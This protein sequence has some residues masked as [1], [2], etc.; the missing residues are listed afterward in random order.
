MASIGT[1]D[2]AHLIP[3]NL[4]PYTAIVILSLGVLIFNFLWNTINMYKP[5][6]GE[7]CTYLDYFK[8]GSTKTH[9]VGML[10]GLI[11]GLGTAFSIIASGA[12]RP[13]R[14]LMD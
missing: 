11:W 12:A 8:K 4:S 2:F 6:A 1:V 14:Y 7:K 13:L 10:G 5:I 9:L 3:G